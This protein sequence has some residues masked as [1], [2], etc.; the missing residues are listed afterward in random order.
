MSTPSL[1]GEDLLAWNNA[2]AERWKSLLSANPMLLQ[3]PCDIY[4]KSSTVGQLLQHIVAAELRYA[5]RLIDAPVTDYA[6]IP[7]TTTDEI[8]ATHTRAVSILNELL[9]NA[10]FD[11]DHEIEFTTLTAGRRC[12]TRR[13]VFHHA[14]LHSIR[15]YAQLATL[16][17][18][19]GLS[20]GPL[21]FLITN[22]HP[23]E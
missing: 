7:Y 3:L 17:R 8:F 16:A 19:H 2:T 4:K 1:T 15:H 5:E 9:A 10:S 12:A 11:W 14:L 13:A 22:S 23:A 21:D 20:P 6:N 18:Q